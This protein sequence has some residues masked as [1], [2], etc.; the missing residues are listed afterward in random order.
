[1]F[2]VVTLA[3]LP[4]DLDSMRDQILASSTDLV[5]DDLFARLL[6]LAAPPMS[7]SHLV[8]PADSSVLASQTAFQ[9]RN[10]HGGRHGKQ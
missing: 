10:R 2:L 7:S 3:G 8:P 6:R 1:M 4:S 5:M 9:T